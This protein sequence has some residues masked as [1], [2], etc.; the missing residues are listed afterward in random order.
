MALPRARVHSHV[1]HLHTHPQEPRPA[2][3]HAPVHA[4]CVCAH[5]RMQTHARSQPPSCTRVC[6]LTPTRTHSHTCACSSRWVA[7]RPRRWHCWHLARSKGLERAGFAR[8]PKPPPRS[9]A[10]GQRRSAVSIRPPCAEQAGSSGAR[11]AARHSAGMGWEKERRRKQFTDETKVGAGRRFDVMTMSLLLCRAD[12]TMPF[13]SQ[14]VAAELAL[15]L[16]PPVPPCPA[17]P[18]G[19]DVGL[20]PTAACSPCPAQSCRGRRRVGGPGMGGVWVRC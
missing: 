7:A 8:G 19:C 1:H 17:R 5:T 2:P 4:Q 14:R 12:V 11:S 18:W 13:G 10:H 20:H 3:V 16:K 15:G 9:A 6:A